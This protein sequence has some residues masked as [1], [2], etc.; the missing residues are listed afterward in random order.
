[1]AVAKALQ[2]GLGQRLAV[3]RV[4]VV[5]PVVGA[6]D[7][8]SAPQRL[9]LAGQNNAGH[10]GRRTVV[11]IVIEVADTVEMR[12]GDAARSVLAEGLVVGG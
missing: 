6:A 5:G 4:F 9:V 3:E 11:E 12:A 7:S 10:V 2:A 1:M 8:K